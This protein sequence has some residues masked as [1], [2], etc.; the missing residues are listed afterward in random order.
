MLVTVSTPVAPVVLFAAGTSTLSY[1]SGSES[2]HAYLIGSAA[3][4]PIEKSVRP[5]AVTV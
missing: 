1:P 3:F 5:R 4:K 2:F